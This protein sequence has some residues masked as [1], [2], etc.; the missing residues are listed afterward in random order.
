MDRKPGTVIIHCRI[1]FPRDAILAYIPHFVPKVFRKE[2]RPV[3]SLRHLGQSLRIRALPEGM[4]LVVHESRV[5]L[6]FI[7]EEVVIG[8]FA[9]APQVQIQR[10]KHILEVF[11]MRDDIVFK[12]V[13]RSIRHVRNIRHIDRN[14][15]IAQQSRDNSLQHA[16]GAEHHRIHRILVRPQEFQ[17]VAQQHRVLP[18]IRSAINA[19]AIDI[20]PVIGLVVGRVRPECRMPQVFAFNQFNNGVILE[21][22]QGNLGMRPIRIRER[23]NGGPAFVRGVTLYTHSV[24]SNT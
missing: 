1:F 16:R 13:L 18:A 14:E 9:I 17:L 19:C 8:S 5:A 20:K 22:N 12:Q 6:V 24:W 23:R 3:R 21:I 10:H 11:D 7:A 15:L 2:F 4:I